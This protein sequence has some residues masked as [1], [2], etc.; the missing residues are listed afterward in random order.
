MTDLKE[1]VIDILEEKGYEIEDADV[2]VERLSQ[3][4]GAV[5]RTLHYKDEL[6]SE[7]EE[8]FTK[9]HIAEKIRD[10]ENGMMEQIMENE[11]LTGDIY[12]GAKK[13]IVARSATYARLEV[14]VYRRAEDLNISHDDEGVTFNLPYPVRRV[15]AASDLKIPLKDEGVVGDESNNSD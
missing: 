6:E 1:A 3:V 14:L 5:Q 15:Q 4:P 7:I 8:N 9:N 2:V 12:L 13:A 11:E 10:A